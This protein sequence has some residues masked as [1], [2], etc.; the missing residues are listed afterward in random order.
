MPILWSIRSEEHKTPG[1]TRL[2]DDF[3]L[4]GAKPYAGN[5]PQA[6][7]V[8]LGRVPTGI[9]DQEYLVRGLCFA[10]AMLRRKKLAGDRYNAPADQRSPES[11]AQAQAQSTAHDHVGTSGESGSQAATGREAG[12]NPGSAS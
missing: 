1:E 8:G 2:E 12:P 7:Q 9:P 4:N 6:L 3:L 10:P 11:L 5:K